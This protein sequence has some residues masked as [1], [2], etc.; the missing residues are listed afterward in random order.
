M[1]RVRG[2]PLVSR[3]V[4]PGRLLCQTEQSIS[5]HLYTIDF[6]ARTTVPLYDL[7]YQR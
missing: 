2:Q 3:N 4:A 6:S 7:L 1:L 5:L